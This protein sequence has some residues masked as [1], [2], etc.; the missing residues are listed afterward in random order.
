MVTEI[1][2]EK[3]KAIENE[4][5]HVGRF[6]I[7]VG[8]NNSGKSSVL[9][10]IQ[11]AVGTAQTGAR[12]VKNPET[13]Q[14]AFTATPSS[15]V[16]LPIKDIEALIHNRALT[17]NQGSS[18]FFSDGDHDAK[19]TLKRGKNR[20]IATTMENSDLLRQLMSSQP[21]CVITPGVSG[22]SISEEYKAKAAVLRSATRGDSNFYLRNILL[23]LKGKADAWNKFIEKFS[24]FFPEY[25][26]DVIFDE[27][28]DDLIEVFAKLPNGIKL[29]ID[30]LGTSALQILQIL[31]YIYFFEPQMI[32]LDEP[33]TH[34]HP[35]N[36]RKLISVLNEISIEEDIQILLSTHSRHIIDEA[37]GIA[38]FFWMQSGKLYKEIPPDGDTDFVDIM[39]DL[40]ALDRSEFLA[41]INI[42][43]IICT[44]DARIDKDKMLNSILCATGFNL[45]ECVIL[46]YKGCGKIESV[47]MLANFIHEFL[48]NAKIIVHRDRDYL[49][50]EVVTQLV[51]DFRAK[52]IHLWVTPTTDV[53]ALFTS[54]EHIR[55]LYPQVGIEQVENVIT[56]AKQETRED[57]I[58]KFVNYIS[59]STRNRDYRAINLDCERKYDEHPDRY[60]YGK[61]TLGLVKSKLQ[62]ILHENL[63]IYRCSPA[64][65]Q[66]DLHDVFVG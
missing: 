22:I 38:T 63:K 13:A 12:Q 6:N 26:L 15:F 37:T 11:F 20:N 8:A 5:F 40:G 34:L 33:D 45:E 54:S 36:Q 41:N 50:D 7:F 64:L 47:V 4:T 14:I 48:P 10:A 65:Y 57:S 46:P 51:T 43:W 25:T 27:E 31:S 28:V 30:A 35:N 3:F 58:A 53:E 29:P 24:L 9:Q 17:Q 49:P 59:N 18:V 32:I 55:Y 23:L 66:Q 19:I 39:L 56:E 16:Y 2:I 42:K 1:R 62:Q 52:G 21:Y 60:F 44:E 61:K